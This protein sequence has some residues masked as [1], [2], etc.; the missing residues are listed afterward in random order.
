MQRVLIIQRDQRDQ[1]TKVQSGPAYAASH[2][3]HNHKAIFVF[4][5]VACIKLSVRK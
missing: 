4:F 3:V 2:M 5:V 1:R